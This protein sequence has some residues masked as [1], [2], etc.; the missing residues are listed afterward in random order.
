MEPVWTCTLA[1]NSSTEKNRADKA[2]KIS[3]T[4]TKKLAI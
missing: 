2:E 1:A 4:P 3:T